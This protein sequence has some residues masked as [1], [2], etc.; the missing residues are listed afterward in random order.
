MDLDI[1]M[2]DATYLAQDTP[3][4]DLPQVD[5]ILVWISRR[6]HCCS[7]SPMITSLSRRVSY[8]V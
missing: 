8:R 4:T 5:D 7:D 2:G 6:H 3:F 1:D